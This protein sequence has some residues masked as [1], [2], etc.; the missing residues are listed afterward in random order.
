MKYEISN[1]VSNHKYTEKDIR[2]HNPFSK[3]IGRGKNRRKRTCYLIDDNP[4]FLLEAYQYG[5]SMK[6]HA[7][8]IDGTVETKQPWV[9]CIILDFDN[10]TKEQFEFVKMVSRYGD[11]SSGMKT[12][13]KEHAGIPNAQPDKWKF[14][15]FFQTIEPTLCV[16]EDVDKAFLCAVEFYNPYHPKDEVKAIWSAWK[17]ANN[18]KSKICDPMFDGWILPDVAMLNNFR[19]QITYSINTGIDK[20]FLELSDDNPTFRKIGLG[21]MCGKYEVTSKWSYRGLDWKVEEAKPDEELKDKPTEAQIQEIYKHLHDNCQFPYSDYSLPTT[22]AAFAKEIG[23]EHFDDLVLPTKGI[24]ILNAARWRQIKSRQMNTDKDMDEVMKNANITAKTFSRIYAELRRQGKTDNYRNQALEDCCTAM[25]FLHGPKLFDGVLTKD[26]KENVLKEMARA[27]MWAWNGHRW[28]RVRQKMLRTVVNPKVLE[29]RNKWKMTHDNDDF[30]KYCIELDKDIKA[31]IVE[32]DTIKWGY[33]YHRWGFK[34]EIIDDTLIPGQVKLNSPDEFIG[35]M[36][37]EIVTK[38]D[39][40]YTDKLLT[41]WFYQ[42]RAKWNSTY[43]ENP[44]GRKQHKS[45]YEELF[46]GMS[47]DEISDTI[48]KLQIHPNMKSRLRNKYGVEI[49]K[50]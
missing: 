9:N 11:Y 49:R 42:Y 16:Y 30:R 50:R 32:A 7:F 22:K 18:R 34:K 27:F 29:L 5:F 23:K 38:K 3:F 14:K 37:M 25:K 19:N 1:L 13:I 21:G 36:R 20:P 6:P 4:K 43:P 24:A 12:W 48:S 26:E 15:V 41:E 17:K 45:K 46:K 33:D 39:G 28:W 2:Y 31:R 44:I 40:V 10:L 8:Q 35:R 47:K